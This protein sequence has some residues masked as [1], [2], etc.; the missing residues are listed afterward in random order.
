MYITV[1]TITAF[2]YL[3]EGVELFKIPFKEVC[4]VV[5]LPTGRLWGII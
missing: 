3:I 2:P 4:D 1:T 5:I